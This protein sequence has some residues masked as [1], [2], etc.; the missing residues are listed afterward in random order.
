MATQPK[1]YMSVEEYLKLE[2]ISFERHEYADGEMFSM[3]GASPNHGL[4]ATNLIAEI[5][6]QLR[7]TGCHVRAADTRVRTSP[8]GP[9]SYPDA[10]ISCK[11][12]QFDGDTLLNPIVLIEVLSPS[13]EGYDRGK[14][15][16]RYREIASFREYLIVSQ[17][18][19]YVEHHVRGKQLS[20]EQVWTMR[21][22]T[23]LESVISFEAVNV[24]LTCAAIYTDVEF[25]VE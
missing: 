11:P 16:Q 12:E 25:S 14:K 13:T 22:F 19:V 7:N 18:Q 8:V 20:G 23:S 21:E 10:V 2:E 1:H 15:F 4:I 5:A 24:Q 17:D 9:Y 3:A 6:S